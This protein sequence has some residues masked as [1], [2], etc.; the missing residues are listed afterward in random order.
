MTRLK[1]KKQIYIGKTRLSNKFIERNIDFLNSCIDR[2]ERKYRY[3][4][5][6]FN[7]DKDDYRQKVLLYA[8]E[9]LGDLEKNFDDNSEFLKQSMYS[10]INSRYFAI[11]VRELEIN[12]H[13]SEMFYKYKGEIKLEDKGEDISQKVEAEQIG[14]VLDND[15]CFQIVNELKQEHNEG[16]QKTIAMKNVM[17]KY[18][19]NQVELLEYMNLYIQIQEEKVAETEL[20]I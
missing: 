17:E 16:I 1:S 18:N 13:K 3:I 19:I 14:D 6:Y 12:Y 4:R 20:E 10:Q 2:V 15:L 9:N 8:I 5:D 11:K 7:I